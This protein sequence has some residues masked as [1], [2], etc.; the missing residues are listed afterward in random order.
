MANPTTP[1]LTYGELALHPE[2][3]ATYSTFKVETVADE[4]EWGNPESVIVAIKSLLQDGSVAQV[5]R[6]DNRTVTILVRITAESYD[7]LAEGEE[8]LAAEVNSEGRLLTWLPPQVDAVPTVMEVVVAELGFEFSDLDENRLRRTY[9]LTLTCMPANRS[10]DETLR[11]A[12]PVPPA[13]DSITVT[14]VDTCDSTS[15]W[16]ATDAATALTTSGGAVRA[17]IIGIPGQVGAP[18]STESH[19]GSLVRTGSVSITG[20]PYLRIEVA[21]ATPTFLINGLIAAVPVMIDV[22]PA[23]GN[24]RYYLR[25][26]ST[27]TSLRVTWV[28]QGNG[29]LDLAVFDVARVSAL[30]ASG[31]T[32]QRSFTLQVEGSARTQASLRVYDAETTALGQDVLVYTRPSVGAVPPPLRP[33]RSSGPT[34]TTDSTLVSGAWHSIQTPVQSVFRIPA[35]LLVP[36]TYA[37]M[38]RLSL[39][40]TAAPFTVESSVKMLTA[41]RLPFGPTHVQSVVVTPAASAS[42]YVYDLARMTLPVSRVDETSTN[43]VELTLV[44]NAAVNLDEAWLFNLDDGALSW[45]DMSADGPDLVLSRLSELF[46]NTATL[47]HPHPEFQVGVYGRDDARRNA[48]YK[49]RAWGVHEFEPGLTDV[50]AITT[51]SLAAQV[52]LSYF[53][54]WHTHARA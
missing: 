16:S 3:A 11:A 20:T 49:V 46:V 19:S 2:S 8:R 32:R 38:A 34:V 5:T 48:D 25:V 7:G 4:T 26:S 39:T 6:M 10:A 15:G 28:V 47:S 33:W 18:P 44:A 53:R 50:F 36:G 14:S 31:T 24:R 41:S 23:T 29:G 54:R 45:V 1:E 35:K 13:P 42:Y 9:R 27:I 21:P 30:P 12:D 17:R 40:S 52:D 22:N 51:G 37:L 43:F